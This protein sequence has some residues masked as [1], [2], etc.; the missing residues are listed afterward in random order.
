M[1][2]STKRR[3]ARPSRVELIDVV[4]ELLLGV[5]LTRQTVMRM[6]VSSATADRWLEIILSKIPR[7]V[8]MRSGN[9]SAY[10]WRGHLVVPKPTEFHV[11]PENGSDD[12]SGTSI[13][14]FK[15]FAKLNSVLRQGPMVYPGGLTINLPSVNVSKRKRR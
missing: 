3:E 1:K 4:R 7:V 9:T 12:N 6:G 2:K 15:T 14:P 11:D 8:K 10:E 13:A 5:R